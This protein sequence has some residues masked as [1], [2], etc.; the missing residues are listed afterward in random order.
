MKAPYND[1]FHHFTSVLFDEYNHKLFLT[2]EWLKSNEE[3]DP[4]HVKHTL[5]SLQD[6]YERR[7][8]SCSEWVYVVTT[9]GGNHDYAVS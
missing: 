3:K 7:C 8:G 5:A 6:V 1:L 2:N 9:R 4:R